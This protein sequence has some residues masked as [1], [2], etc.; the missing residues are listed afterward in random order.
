[1]VEFL[2]NDRNAVKELGRGGASMGKMSSIKPLSSQVFEIIEGFLYTVQYGQLILAIQ[3]GIVVKIE[4][5]EKF[6]I[7]TKNREA[8]CTKVDKSLKKHPLQTKILTELQSIRYGQL[9][10]RLDNGQVEQ[11]EKTEK[12]RVNELEGLYGDGI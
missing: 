11:I 12:R 7:S 3:D 4:K 2:V 5:I 1:M 10:I 6:I 9:V 8:K